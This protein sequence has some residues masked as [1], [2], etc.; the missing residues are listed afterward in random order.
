MLAVTSVFKPRV[1]RSRALSLQGSAAHR[2]FSYCPVLWNA[3]GI[4]TSITFAR[5][6]ARSVMTSAGVR[7]ANGDVVQN[8]LSDAIS[9]RRDTETSITCQ[10]WSTARHTYR[11]TPLTLTYVSFTNHRSPTGCRLGLLDVG[12]TP[13]AALNPRTTRPHDRAVLGDVSSPSRARGDARAESVVSPI[14]HG[15]RDHAQRRDLRI[16]HGLRIDY[17]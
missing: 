5:A 6:A 7:C 14:S 1:G 10:C 9:V 8:R 2:L 11:H 3:A 13:R 16:P 4:R 17:P 15:Q 12:R